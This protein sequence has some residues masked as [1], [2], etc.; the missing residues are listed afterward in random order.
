LRP[1]HS[2]PSK[3]LQAAIGAADDAASDPAARAMTFVSQCLFSSLAHAQRPCRANHVPIHVQH[4][5][6][7]PYDNAT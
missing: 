7:N 1:R 2:P 6:S 4:R 3:I 5:R